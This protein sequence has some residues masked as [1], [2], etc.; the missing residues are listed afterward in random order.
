M[1]ALNP[2][3]R[4]TRVALLIVGLGLLLWP[5]AYAVWLSFA[6]GELL[7]PPTGVW[8]LRW[9]QAFFA[10]RRW[11]DGLFNSF[12]VATMSALFAALLGTGL[13]VGMVGAFGGAS[14]SRAA[15]LGRFVLLPL[16]IPP[17]VLGMALL[18]V[19]RA[20]GLWGSLLSLAIAHSLLGLPVVYVVVRD[21]LTAMDSNL[22][23]AARGLGAS[24]WLTLRRVTLP[25]LIPAIL[26][27]ALTAFVFSMNEFSIALF[28]A[29]PA[30][31][32]LPKVIWPQLRY[33]LTPLVAAASTLSVLSAVTL[34]AIA[35]LLRRWSAARG[36]AVLA[37]P[38][39]RL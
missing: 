24:R 16:F 27:G 5:L 18:P 12:I 38:V 4:S 34:L 7:E 26:F 29:T 23:F 37:A 30:I 6:P 19:M 28:L 15:L 32:T 10:S 2:A 1:S 36:G 22:A 33:T 8:S 9:Y 35:L 39:D 17:V 21:S 25:P 13:A 31:E 11:T 14:G 20:I 3:V